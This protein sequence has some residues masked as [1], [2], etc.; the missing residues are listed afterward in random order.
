KFQT[1]ANEFTSLDPSIQSNDALQGI[2][3]AADDANAQ[4]KKLS[5]NGL[6][7]GAFSK[8]IQAAALANAAAKTGAQIQVLAT[9]G[10]DAFIAKIKASESISG[11]VSGLVD[12]LKTIQPKT[13]ADAGALVGAYGNAV[14]AVS[15]SVF[16]DNLFNAKASSQQQ[17]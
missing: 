7:A 12:T 5:A 13:V 6:Q 11:A 10:V 1:S 4:A 8:A 14:D 17:A 2:A 15:L 3:Q 16:G 9:Q